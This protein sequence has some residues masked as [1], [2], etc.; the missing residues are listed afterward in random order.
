MPKPKRETKK[1]VIEDT[2]RVT[3]NFRL[4]LEIQMKEIKTKIQLLELEVKVA[5]LKMEDAERRLREAQEEEAYD[6][7]LAEL[8]RLDQ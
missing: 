4:K 3:R 5:N 7:L 1:E 6:C 2:R 8:Q